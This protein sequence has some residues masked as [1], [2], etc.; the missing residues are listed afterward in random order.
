ME[1][2]DAIFFD[3]IR[4]ALGIQKN[5]AHTPSK[6]EW[7]VL[8][9]MAQKQSLIGIC[10][11]AL[12][13]MGGNSEE[14]WKA[15]GIPEMVYLKWMAKAAVIRKRNEEVNRQ[16]VEIGKNLKEDGFCYYILK[17]QGVAILYSDS[18]QG[19]RQ[20][21]DIDVLMWKEGFSESENRRA[22]IDYAKK[23][24]PAAKA[25]EHHIVVSLFPDT[26]V[27][28]HYLP[29][30]LCNPMAN[31]RFQQWCL[32]HR[33]LQNASVNAIEQKIGFSTPSLEYNIVFLLAHAFRHYMSEGV[34]LRQMMDYYFVLRTLEVKG[35]GLK[36]RDTL[37]S[38]NMLKFAGAV[39]WVLA[40]VFEDQTQDEGQSIQVRDWMICEPNEKLGRKLLN[41]IMKGGNFGHHNED[42]V[43][44]KNTHLGR[45]VNQVANDLHLAIDYPGE[46]LWAPLSMIREFVR[47]R[48]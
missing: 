29:A 10:F 41:H 11:N 1:A 4:V 23:I 19:L 43:M 31:K 36:H 8:Y 14:G 42:T 21:G 12:Q 17:G 44:E 18:L 16:C 26:E 39:M 24:D 25:S 7:R 38:F 46:A 15:L 30:Y 22:V 40:T 13:R 20:S 34:G 5:L 28:M 37:R 2:I 27:E 3:L 9:A 32:L 47:I 45:F 35:K 48:I 33:D 6:E